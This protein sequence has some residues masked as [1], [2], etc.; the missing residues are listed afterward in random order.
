M[1][2]I[3]NPFLTFLDWPAL[4]NLFSLIVWIVLVYG[5]L[6]DLKCSTWLHQSRYLWATWCMKLQ[7]NYKTIN[8]LLILSGH[9]DKLLKS[10]AHKI[11]IGCQ[12]CVVHLDLRDSLSVGTSNK[13]SYLTYT[14]QLQCFEYSKG[15]NT[16][17]HVCARTDRHTRTPHTYYTTRMHTYQ[18]TYS[19]CTCTHKHWHIRCRIKTETSNSVIASSS[20][21]LC[22]W[23]GGGGGGS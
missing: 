6:E 11:I 19:R 8:I 10:A 4:E 18:S 22:V 16:Y 20:F 21:R 13:M 5:S 15:S 3:N 23:G 2:I 17:T 7:H 12:G 9:V 14:S 1:Q